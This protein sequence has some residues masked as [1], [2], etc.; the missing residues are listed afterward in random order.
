M[1]EGGDSPSISGEAHKQVR[2]HKC[3]ALAEGGRRARAWGAGPARTSSSRR[4]ELNRVAEEDAHTHRQVEQRTPHVQGDLEAR[5]LPAAVGRGQRVSKSRMLARG[6]VRA[7]GEG[8]TGATGAAPGSIQ[9]AA[10]AAVTGH[11]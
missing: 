10:G 3:K 11:R 5:N 2:A 1:M 9:V 6:S 8:G 4:D 7:S